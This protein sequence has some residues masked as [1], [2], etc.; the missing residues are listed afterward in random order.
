[1]KLLFDENLSPRLTK[2]LEDLFPG[3]SHVSDLGLA[4]ADDLAIWEEA[5]SGGFTIV[6]HDSDFADWNKL[7]GAPPRIVWLRCGNA[8]VAEIHAKLRAASDRICLMEQITEFEVVE[9]W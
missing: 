6:T 1:M 9:V 5:Q 7:R 4:S 2:L 8:T 3:S